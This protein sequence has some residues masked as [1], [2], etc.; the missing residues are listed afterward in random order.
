ME[1]VVKDETNKLVKENKQIQAFALTTEE[2][3]KLKNIK[4]RVDLVEKE[5]YSLKLEEILLAK[6]IGSRVS[7]NL[8]DYTVNTANGRCELRKPI[9]AKD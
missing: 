3:L 6:D 9:S 5:K 8:D 1:E 2:L 4:L 7:V